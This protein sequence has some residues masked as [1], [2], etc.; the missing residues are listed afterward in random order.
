M[1][2]REIVHDLNITCVKYHFG[3]KSGVHV[4]FGNIEL[5]DVEVDEETRKIVIDTTP[6]DLKRELRVVVGYIRAELCTYG[7]PYVPGALM[8]FRE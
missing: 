7:D 4:K 8:A 5:G 2:I 1:T 6:V 3:G